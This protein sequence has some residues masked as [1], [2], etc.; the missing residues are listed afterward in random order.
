[1][2]KVN[3]FF[4]PANW[5]SSGVM[6][7]LF[8][9]MPGISHAATVID[10]GSSEPGSPVAGQEFYRTDSHFYEIYDGQWVS[11]DMEIRNV[12]AWGAKGDGSTNDTTAIQNAINDTPAGGIV[13][14]PNGIYCISSISSNKSITFKGQGWR[15]N[16]SGFFGSASWTSNGYYN[17]SILKSSATSGVAVDFNGPSAWAY[18]MEDLAVVGPGSGNSVGIKMQAGNGNPIVHSRWQRVAVF[19]FSEGVDLEFC[20][21]NTFDFLQI[22]GCTTG[23]YMGESTNSNNI[24]GLNVSHASTAVALYNNAGNAFLRPLIENLNTNGKGFVFNQSSANNNNDQ[25]IECGWFEH[26]TGG[27]YP[28]VEINGGR[29]ISIIRGHFAGSGRID[30]NGGY[31]HAVMFSRFTGGNA[32]INVD[33][34]A[35]NTMLFHNDFDGAGMSGISDNSTTTQIYDQTG[36][37]TLPKTRGSLTISGSNNSATYNLGTTL[38]DSNYYVVAT[39]VSNSGSPATGSNR[40][41]GINKTTSGFAINIETAPGVNNSVT[42]NW[43]LIR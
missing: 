6:W 33:S 35:S 26:G 23:L 37:L 17:G 5:L 4:K 34:D 8:L 32:V 7:M 43:I 13:Y 25:L 22:R 40:V 15:C 12:R 27:P 18:N 3:C 9:L 38:P 19:N 2:F 29:G 28:S 1:M 11:M 24:T 14:F 10:H 41:T 42:F 36:Y 21:N 16:A 39:P 30:I 31:N 20:I